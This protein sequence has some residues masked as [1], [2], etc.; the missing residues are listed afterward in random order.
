MRRQYEI[1]AA[2]PQ[3]PIFFFGGGGGGEGKGDQGG[4]GGPKGWLL[5]SDYFTISLTYYF[6]L[7]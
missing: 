6:I 7:Q 3:T 5:C 4:G 2:V 1:S